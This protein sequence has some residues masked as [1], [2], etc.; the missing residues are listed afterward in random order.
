MM[1]TTATAWPSSRI[2]RPTSVGSAPNRRVH[3]A[4]PTT[5][6]GDAPGRS[7]SSERSRPMHRRHTK[8]GEIRVRHGGTAQPLRLVGARQVRHPSSH[9]R[10][11][12]E[13]RRPALPLDEQPRRRPLALRSAARPHVLP[14]HDQPVG[15]GVGE[16]LQQYAGDDAEDGGVGTKAERQGDE[17][18][19]QRA[20]RPPPRPP[21]S[22]LA[23]RMSPCT[24]VTL[25]RT[26]E[27]L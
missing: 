5:A 9:R 15:I 26:Y 22:T 11:M 12:L 10:D 2:V 3:S 18:C 27:D 23:S 16:G 14:D 19:R 17:C 20:R 8:R 21:G 25:S 4:W 6:T 7:S 24:A 1:P 13:G